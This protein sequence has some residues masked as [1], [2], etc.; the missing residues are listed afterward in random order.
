MDL[1]N[2][3]EASVVWGKMQN[4]KVDIES[5]PSP[6]TTDCW[7]GGLENIHQLEKMVWVLKELWKAT[8]H[9]VK[10]LSAGIIVRGGRS[11]SCVFQDAPDTCTKCWPSKWP[12]PNFIP[13]IY[14]PSKS[15][16]TKKS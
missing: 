2:N 3:K 10:G 1:Y 11:T 6:Q 4:T 5:L 8:R 9:F 14:F 7:L 15:K 12:H 16:E 13:H